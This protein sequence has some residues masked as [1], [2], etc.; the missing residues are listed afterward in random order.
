MSPGHE[1][2][3]PQ[4]QPGQKQ[5]DHYEELGT[6]VRPA[7][8]SGR[9]ERFISRWTSGADG[10]FGICLLC[11]LVRPEL[12][13]EHGCRP[14]LSDDELR[15]LGVPVEAPTKQQAV[16]PHDDPIGWALQ[17]AERAQRNPVDELFERR[18]RKRAAEQEQQ[19]RA[20]AARGF[21]G[22]PTGAPARRLAGACRKLRAT[23]EGARNDMLNKL[24][25][26]LA[27]ELV[28]TGELPASI[29]ADELF[30][31]A[32]DAGLDESGIEATLHSAFRAQGVPL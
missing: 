28:A 23:A 32:L 2:G 19:R 11:G 15:Q 24:A 12:P 10:S 1:A 31:A 27:G 3:P 5:L 6:I 22:T 16:D 4:G 29:V 30:A 8:G 13:A 17:Q 7:G 14:N 20:R 25:H 9:A 21:V 26:L 18:D